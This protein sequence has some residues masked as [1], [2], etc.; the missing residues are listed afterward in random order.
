MQPQPVPPQT[1]LSQPHSSTFSALTKL[2]PPK[3]SVSIRWTLPL[4]VV[5][6]LIS[7]IVL[8]SWLA[9]RS[10]QSAVEELVGKICTEVAANIEKRV[11]SY[12][13]TPSMIS[14][15]I[16]AEVASGNIDIDNVRQLGQTLWHLTQDDLLSSNLYYG[17][18]FGEFVYS[19]NQ[20]GNSRLDF[21]D[22]ASGFRR[23]AYKTDDTGTPTRELTRKD[24]DPR[25]RPWYQEAAD[26][27]APIWS[28]VYVA[29][30]TADLTL[31][32]ATP[33]FD[34]SGQLKGIFG[35]DVYLSELSDFL[36]DLTISRN[37]RAFIME[38]S[39]ELIA[40]SADEKPFIDQGE[41][42]LRLPA[43]ESQ[44]ALVKA[45]AVH[46]AEN[47]IE[48]SDSKNQYYFEFELEGQKQL[49]YIY[50][51]QEMGVDWVIGVVIP[52]NDYMGTI[53]AS[54]RRT[55]VVGSLISVVA[56]L[57][58]L[59]AALYIVRPINKLNQAAQDIK[60]N[61]FDPDH[62]KGVMARPDEFSELAELFNDMA[63][64]VVSREQTL[65]EQVKLLKTEIS[66][67]GSPRS[68]RYE[69]EAL[70]RRAKQM[71]ASYTNRP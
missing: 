28:Q 11:S 9:F 23:I 13:A 48:F 41:D 68:T 36:R 27:A 17:N 55:L 22:E 12:L 67:Q 37:G 21:V 45:T 66:Q 59:G 16:R 4:F 38:P 71:R 39:G 62:L 34:Q 53:H 54:A 15:G 7:G 70:L 63:I 69:L 5:T 24:Y 42:K 60:H 46:L 61:R 43:T 35:I 26:Q 56:S 57:L 1:K 19:Q 50:P 47:T 2:H 8:T 6:P 20:D 52:Q 65:S 64:V 10:G 14:A 49:A 31:T 18:E 51:L 25:N 58:A 44:D 30:S 29:T 40:I 32:R 33:I 3:Q